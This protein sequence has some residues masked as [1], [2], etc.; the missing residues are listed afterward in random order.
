[1]EGDKLYHN[2]TTLALVGGLFE[3]HWKEDVALCVGAKAKRIVSAV[4]R[5]VRFRSLTKGPLMLPPHDAVAK[6]EAVGRG[7]GMGMG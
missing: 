6:G 7:E 5:G 1:L 3:I 2:I 4:E